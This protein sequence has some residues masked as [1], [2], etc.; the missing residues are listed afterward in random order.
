MQQLGGNFEPCGSCFVEML[1]SVESH[2]EIE[3]QG[4][5]KIVEDLQVCKSSSKY[6]E[7]K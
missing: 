3:H 2:C 7:H 5:D 6:N 4:L 1:A